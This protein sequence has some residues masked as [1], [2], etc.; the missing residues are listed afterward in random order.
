MHTEIVTLKVVDHFTPLVQA[1]KDLLET[2]PAPASVIAPD[3]HAFARVET[4]VA[5]GS[6]TCVLMPT[7]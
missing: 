5:R 7:P 4:I 1:M 6:I 2:I 3:W